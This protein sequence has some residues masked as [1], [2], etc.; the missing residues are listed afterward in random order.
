[1]SLTRIPNAAKTAFKRC[2][3]G[4][5]LAAMT[6]VAAGAT[7]GTG[8]VYP[9]GVDTVLS[10]VAPGP[11]GTMFLQ[12]DTSYQANKLVD[13][14]GVSLMPGFHLRVGAVAEKIVHNWGVHLLGGTLVSAFA[15]PL[16][17][18]HVDGP[19]G[20]ANKTGFGNPELG[21][22]Y[23]AYAHGA[24]HWWYGLDTY[25]PGFGY[26]KNALVNIGQHNWATVP[27][28]AFSCL[29]DHGRTE[30]SSRFQYIVNFTDPATNYHSGAEFTW[31]YAAMRNITKSLA[32]GAN[33]YYHQQ[34]TDDFQS[35][36]RVADGHRG[37]DF[38]IGPELRYH[39]GS[40]ALIAKYQRDTLVE[41]RPVGNSFWFQFGM[42][43]GH[44]PEH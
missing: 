41:N 3:A 40:C 29:P 35:G 28:G 2:F 26:Q 31:E 9:L 36:L 37:R 15:I 11:G 18:E 4:G 5:L 8:S 17:Y 43:V 23:V 32:I 25:T 34:A 27:V 22:A 10:G 24:W 14:N 44:K 6:I 19:F 12:F 1:M 16:M 21:L 39:L 30:L 38:A 13:S 7:E 42:P 33:G 20:K